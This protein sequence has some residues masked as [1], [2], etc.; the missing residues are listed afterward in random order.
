[1]VCR[2]LTTALLLLE[3]M[4]NGVVLQS[5]RQLVTTSIVSPLLLRTALSPSA[6]FLSFSLPLSS[7][8]SFCLPL[9]VVGCSGLCVVC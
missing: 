3:T 4:E 7:L 5:L 1:M 9:S 8:Q 2:Q 6:L